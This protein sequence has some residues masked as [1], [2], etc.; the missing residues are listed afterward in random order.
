MRVAAIDCG[1]NSLR[2]LVLEQEPGGA[3][4]ELDRQLRLVRL[5][6]GVDATGEFAPAAIERTFGVLREYAAELAQL[7]V[8]RVRFVATSAARDVG[9]A[10]EFLAGVRR[11]LGVQGEIISGSEE[12]ALTFAGA[13]TGMP[14]TDGAVLVTDIGGGSTELVVG[15]AGIERSASLDMGSVRLRE[16]FL[17]S[18][19]PTGDELTA[20]ME[21]VDDQLA[22]F[23]FSDVRGWVGVAGTIT[24]MGA[25]LLGLDHYDRTLV[26]GLMMDRNAIDAVAGGLC[27][28]PVAEL[29]SPLLPPLRAEVIAGGAVICSRIAARVDVPM[30]VSEHDI[31][32][33][34]AYGLLAEAAGD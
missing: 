1:T 27:A 30:I 6:E 18:D 7:D 22:T 9:N 32:D 33:G 16:R 29:V 8:Q 21:F 20:A 34:V 25:L 26:Q 2:L 10:A 12:A 11:L 3:V 23:D 19:P 5:G 28:T 14:P 17:A 15:H 31:L 4:V 13:V 24:S